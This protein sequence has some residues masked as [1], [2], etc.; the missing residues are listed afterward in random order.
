MNRPLRSAP[1]CVAACCGCPW[2]HKTLVFRSMDLNAFGCTLAAAQ[3]EF[4]EAIWPDGRNPS[5]DWDGGHF[6]LKGHVDRPVS[7][8]RVEARLLANL[9]TLLDCKN[10]LEV[11]TGFGYS[12]LWMAQGLSLCTAPA[13]VITFDDQT[14]GDL[15]GLGIEVARTLWS[16]THLERFVDF[17]PGR[18]PEALASLTDTADLAFIDAEHHDGRPLLD[19]QGVVPHLSQ[20]ACVVFHDVQAKYDVAEAVSRAEQDGF[21]CVRL[22]TSCEMVV[23]SRDSRSLAAAEISLSLARRELLADRAYV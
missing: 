16:R 8:S 12:T 20:H 19:Y 7:V 4:L 13:S 5:I 6:A 17:R 10:V 11:G 18:S 23:A 2:P 14:E 9:V 1:P 3:V 15:G 21:A 22:G